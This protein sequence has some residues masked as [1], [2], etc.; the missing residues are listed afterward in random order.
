MTIR[1]R[2]Y[3]RVEE[4]TTTTGTGT[5]T[6]AGATS[7]AR[8]FQS[9][10]S[11]GD[12][13]CYVIEHETADEWEVVLGTLATTTTLS[14][15][16]IIASSNSGS[17][18]SF[19]AGTKKVWLTAPADH[20]RDLGMFGGSTNDVTIS[21]STT[22]AADTW[23]GNLTLQHTLN[24]A[25]Y[26]FCVS[27][28]L[29]VNHASA[30]IALTG[31]VGT[32]GTAGANNTTG[33]AGGTYGAAVASV[34][35]GG[36]VRGGS[37][38]R[39]GDSPAN[40]NMTAG[41]SGQATDT[42][43]GSGGNGGAGQQSGSGGGSGGSVANGHR[44]IVSTRPNDYHVAFEGDGTS[45]MLGGCGG[46]GGGGAGTVNSRGGAGGGGGGGGAPHLAVF[47]AVLKTG[48]STPAACIRA[49]AG[50]GGAGGAHAFSGCGGSGGG[51]G[52]G[53]LVTVIVGE[54][55][56]TAVTGLIRSKGGDGG[57]LGDGTFDGVVG[58][59]GYGG[60]VFAVNLH[61]GAANKSGPTANSGQTGGSTTV[62][63]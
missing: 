41:G 57:A 53:G 26:Y 49:D 52:G 4:T 10:M 59:G 14:R 42:Y 30:L 32:V 39:G 45:L 21:G 58:G 8:T 5:V 15:D 44:P 1:V 13:C 55:I 2:Q 31:N 34:T 11:T 37:G 61:T 25:G 33:Q 50:A 24:P 22:L 20:G 38:G 60:P 56:G 62:N 16:H 47:A 17:A 19:S 43:G 27:G 29:D 63:F 9:I 54:R 3:E 46:G 18:V 35:W 51:G 12:L 7:K 40:A 28:V 36:S 6:L 48:A 23:Y